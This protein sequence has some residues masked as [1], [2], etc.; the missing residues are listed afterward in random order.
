MSRPN[1]NGVYLLWLASKAR[2]FFNFS[3]STFFVFSFSFDL[4]N[5]YYQPRNKTQIGQCWANFT[6][7]E[8]F[9]WLLLQL[10]DCNNNNQYSLTSCSPVG[11]YGCSL[12][13]KFCDTRSYAALRA[14]DLDWIVGPG[15]FWGVLN[16]SL[17]AFGTQLW[18]L[19]Y[20]VLFPYFVAFFTYFSL[21]FSYFW[22]TF[23]VDTFERIFIFGKQYPW[24]GFPWLIKDYL[25]KPCKPT[26]N[27]EKQWNY[28]E[29][30]WKPTKNLEKP[31]KPTKNHDL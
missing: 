21:T 23:G 7:Q 24:S 19:Y 29:K 15:K 28:L 5:R 6:D 2:L 25:E 13:A 17:R 11:F 30:S 1:S 22:C 16:V 20:N 9:H 4:P 8:L 3:I 12:P 27:H 14:A 18:F 10:A 31:C 26:K